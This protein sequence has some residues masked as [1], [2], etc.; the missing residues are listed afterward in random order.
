MSNPDRE[1]L[2][3]TL[4]LLILKAVSAT[5]MH[6]WGLTQRIR[7]MSREVLSVNPGSL[8]PALERLQDR[9]WIEPRWGVTEN[10]R[11]AKFYQLTA[12]GR[13]R[14]E[15]ETEAWRRLVVGVNAVLRT[16]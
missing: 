10:N 11:R 3:G 2:Q 6:A 1:L 14:L 7:E 12:S 9:G 16:T 4:D 13:K 8:Y 5:P 15:V